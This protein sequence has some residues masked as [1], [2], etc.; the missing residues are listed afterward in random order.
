MLGHRVLNFSCVLPHG[1]KQHWKK[2]LL[3][4]AH[5]IDDLGCS[6]Q[7]KRRISSREDLANVR[8]SCYG[9]RGPMAE[10]WLPRGCCRKWFLKYALGDF[11]W[12]SIS[13]N[14]PKDLAAFYHDIRNPNVCIDLFC[15]LSKFIICNMHVS[16]LV[17]IKHKYFLL[18]FYR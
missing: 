4:L 11:Y 15:S 7:Q 1:I 18:V 14:N 10:M 17:L 2:N 12:N 13:E 5:A 3:K 9:T 6:Y 16:P 8:T